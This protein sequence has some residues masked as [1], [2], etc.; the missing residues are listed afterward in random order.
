MIVDLCGAVGVSPESRCAR[1][2]DVPRA[3]PTGQPSLVAFRRVVDLP[4]IF[5]HVDLADVDIDQLTV[6]LFDAADIDVLNNIALRGIDHNGTARAIEL[7]ALH[8]LD[9]LGAVGVRS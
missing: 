7:L 3:A 9:V 4:G 2:P 1:N 6:A 8:G 5:N